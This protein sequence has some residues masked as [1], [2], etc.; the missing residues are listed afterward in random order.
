MLKRKLCE[1]VFT[2]EL[3]CEGPLL[4][5]DGRYEKPA[6]QTNKH[7]PDKMFISMADMEKEVL[8][9]V[10]ANSAKAPESLPFYVPGTSLRGPFRGQAERI[11]R[12]LLPEDAKSGMTACDPFEQDS[13]NKPDTLSCSKRLEQ[14]PVRKYWAACP[15]CKLF[16][17]AGLASRIVF[18]DSKIQSYHSAYR[19]M[20]GIDRFTGGVYSSANMRFH[21]LEDATFST[22][23]MVTN[24]ELWQL[25]LIAY[26]FQDF[27]DEL[28]PVGFGKTKGFGRVQGRV[29][30]IILTYPV[31]K[32][33]GKIE[34][35]GT[36][37]ATEQEHYDF[38]PA[39]APPCGLEKQP[40]I[41]LSLYE[42][43]KVQ[44]LDAFWVTVAPAFNTFLQARV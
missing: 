19:D 5:A 2:W 31:G 20:I 25:G 9:S 13:E 10:R 30:E 29:S 43:F 37:A 12:S 15:A 40:N 33:D 34:H 39:P 6:S 17:C 35:L 22:K 7:Y 14:V 36:L 21:V 27:A 42:T 44:D 28:V 1:A 23:V 16:G 38:D 26:V 3:R 24:F 4:I 11:I 8:R 32:A 41:G 18:E